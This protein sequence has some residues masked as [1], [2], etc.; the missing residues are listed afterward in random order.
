MFQC[1]LKLNVCRW[2][3]VSAV[4]RCLVLQDDGSFL[5]NLDREKDAT[6]KYPGYQIIIPTK[7]TDTTFEAEGKAVLSDREH[8]PYLEKCSTAGR[9][10]KT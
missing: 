7:L 4:I 2:A 9:Q 8:W 3:R 6:F 1:C 10:D 5:V